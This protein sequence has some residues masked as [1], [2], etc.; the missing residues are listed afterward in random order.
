MAYYLVLSFYLNQ[1]WLMVNPTL[2]NKLPWNFNGN[3][4][5]FIEEN[6]FENVICHMS[7]ILYGP[8][9][10]WFHES[11][12]RPFPHYDCLGLMLIKTPTDFMMASSNGNIFG[13][14]GPLCNSPVTGDF[15][16]QRPVMRSFDLCMNKRLSKKNNWDTIVL[17]MTSLYCAWKISW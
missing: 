4:D 11:E 7:A 10:S 8:Q 5:I 16:S 15:P 13:V 9:L 12:S 2:W 1:Y 6:A 14:T 17:I 3:S